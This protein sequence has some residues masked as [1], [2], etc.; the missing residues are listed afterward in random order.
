MARPAAAGEANEDF[1]RSLRAGK[2]DDLYSDR[3]EEELEQEE[4][5]MATLRE[6]LRDTSTSAPSQPLASRPFTLPAVLQQVFGTE[7]EAELLA[8]ARILSTRDKKPLNLVFHTPIGSVKTPVVWSSCKPERLGSASELLLVL[9]RSSEV[10]F[11]PD[12]GAQ[13]DISFAGYGDDARLSVT[14]LA[15]PMQL[16]AGVGIDLLCFL[17]H[18]PSVEKRGQL[19]P[20]APSAVSGAVSNAVD[21]EGEPVVDGEKSAS[22]RKAFPPTEEKPAED[23]DRPRD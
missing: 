14:C 11:A 9:V 7:A 16:Y 19:K 5:D 22:F 20:G 13:C 6:Q 10:S 21:E 17:P 4:T 23:Y 18:I 3:D 2:D 1:V 12:P 15:R 8:V